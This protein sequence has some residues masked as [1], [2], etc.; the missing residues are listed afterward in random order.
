[1]RKVSLS[2]PTE[3]ARPTKYCLKLTFCGHLEYHTQR[4]RTVSGREDGMEANAGKGSRSA[5][6]HVTERCKESAF[7]EAGACLSGHVWYHFRRM[8]EAE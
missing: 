2:S 8:E 3:A 6:V 7:K 1:M 4:E 5:G